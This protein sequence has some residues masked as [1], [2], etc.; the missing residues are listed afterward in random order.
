[1]AEI[2]KN[3]SEF[4][5]RPDTKITITGHEFRVLQHLAQKAMGNSSEEKYELK[6]EWINQKTGK[7]IKKPTQKQINEGTA[8]QVPS[9]EQTFEKPTVFYDR[10][11]YPEILDGNNVLFNIHLRN[12][13]TDVAVHVEVLKDEE[14]RNK[15][16]E[17][18]KGSM[19]VVEDNEE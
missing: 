8:V 19:K 13:E 5:Y 4:S 18:K 7:L 9:K 2:P 14:K 3:P 17:S 10:N 6:Y 12:I 11:V 15:E 1:M 16:Q